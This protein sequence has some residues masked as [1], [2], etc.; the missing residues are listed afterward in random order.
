MRPISNQKS[1]GKKKEQKICSAE[2][3][4]RKSLKTVSFFICAIWINMHSLHALWLAAVQT[5]SPY[6]HN[7]IYSLGYL[8]IWH[9]IYLGEHMKTT[10]KHK[11]NKT[12]PCVYNYTAKWVSA[13]FLSL[14]ISIFFSSDLSEVFQTMDLYFWFYQT[15]WWAKQI[16]I[17][18]SMGSVK[19]TIICY[20]LQIIL[21]IAWDLFCC[22]CCHIYIYICLLICIYNKWTYHVQWY[23][24]MYKSVYL[25]MEILKKCH[26]NFQTL[27]IEE[28]L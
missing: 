27:S 7:C 25:I 9:A 6:K 12:L 14:C 8:H 5:I 3:L 2:D 11:E 24:Y 21:A 10:N 18:M 23:I 16:L 13:C 26:K 17:Q 20:F 4:R 22:C 15:K 28:G 19:G 1:Y